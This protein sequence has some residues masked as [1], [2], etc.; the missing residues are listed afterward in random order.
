MTCM[1]HPNV[2]ASGTC[3]RCGR[4]IYVD[5][6]DVSLYEWENAPMCPDCNVGTVTEIRDGAAAQERT[7][8]NSSIFFGIM[9]VGGIIS[10]MVTGSL[11]NMFGWFATAGFLTAWRTSDQRVLCGSIEGIGMAL[12]LKIFTCSIVGAVLAPI[13]F[14]KMLIGWRKARQA[15]LQAEADLAE[16]Q[17]LHAALP[18]FFSTHQTMSA[19]PAREPLNVKER[20]MAERRDLVTYFGPWKRRSVVSVGS[21]TMPPKQSR[22]SMPSNGMRGLRQIHVISNHG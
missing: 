12:C 22:P 6:I 10:G 17:R 7:C 9:V 8:R 13:I 20:R 1:C 2:E 19:Q 16:L 15:R 5:C 21:R 3:G 11:W 18:R 14:V 4:G